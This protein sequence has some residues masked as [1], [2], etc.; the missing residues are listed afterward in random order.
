MKYILIM[1]LL[2]LLL[3]IVAPLL[4]VQSANYSE[5]N[6]KLGKIYYKLGIIVDKLYSVSWIGLLLL[7][8]IKALE[9]IF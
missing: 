3:R 7:M 9:F 2:T 5:D 4:Y 6:Y 8:V 1:I